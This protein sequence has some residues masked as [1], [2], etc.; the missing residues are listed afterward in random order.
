MP[1]TIV[2]DLFG[3]IART[4]SEAAQ[5]RLEELAGV[6]GPAFWTAY[7][8]GRPVYD[9]GQ[10]SADYWAGVADRLGVRFDAA[11]VD[12]LI[13]VDLASWTEAD[14][15]M[16]E[17]VAELAGQGRSLGLL[18]NIIED[19]VPV[20]EGR[21]GRWLSLFAA[22]TYSCQIGVVKPDP[23]AYQICAEQ[24]GVRPEDV[25]FFDDS[26][27]NVVGARASGMTAEVFVSPDQVRERLGLAGDPRT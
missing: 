9:A 3:V 1:Q 5:R 26:E 7:W 23:R 27:P 14:E 19:L 16:V 24:L 11:T 13:E 6:A 21:H 15:R 17:L 20:F 4:Q 22:R 25:L 18:S 10:R 2:F 12:A 8:A